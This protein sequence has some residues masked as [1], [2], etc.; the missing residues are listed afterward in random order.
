MW[1][2]IQKWVWHSEIDASSGF[3]AVRVAGTGIFK[4]VGGFLTTFAPKK[5]KE[6][7]FV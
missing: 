2:L 7:N 4:K 5:K 1:I 3:I 6:V